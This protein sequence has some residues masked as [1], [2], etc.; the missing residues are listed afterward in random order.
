MPKNSVSN[1]QPTDLLLAVFLPFKRQRWY[2]HLLMFVGGITIAV[3]AYVGIMHAMGWNHLASVDSPEALQ[4]RRRA[5]A[6]AL[7]VTGMYSMVFWLRGYGGLCLSIG[8]AA[9]AFMTLP[10]AVFMLFGS[11]DASP[12]ITTSR[13]NYFAFRREVIPTVIPFAL[14]ISLI[15]MIPLGYWACDDPKKDRKAAAF[16]R[17]IP[18][19]Q[20]RVFMQNYE[21]SGPRA[22]AVLW[23]AGAAP[24]DVLDGPAA[25]YVS[26]DPTEHADD[27]SGDDA[28]LRELW[29]VS[30][31]ALLVFFSN[32]IL[33]YLLLVVFTLIAVPIGVYSHRAEETG[34]DD[35]RSVSN[36]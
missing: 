4:A 21:N 2:H 5:A 3:G 18:D 6:V 22:Q 35:D 8:Y 36:S 13:I 33:A 24:D 16:L 1:L 29:A 20:L 12:I 25:Q 30:V 17:Q 11:L 15:A 28:S 26:D 32:S 9:L 10:D 7:A 34:A 19:H 14:T 23:E 27:D 31:A